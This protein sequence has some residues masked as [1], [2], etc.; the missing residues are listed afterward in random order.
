MIDPRGNYGGYIGTYGDNL[1]D[2]AKLAHDLY[3]GYS[4]MVANTK[5]NEIVRKVF[6]E[7][8]KE[9]NLPTDLVLKGGLVL[10]ATCIPLHSDDPDRQDRF[11]SYVETEINSF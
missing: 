6:L 10:L 4:A 5:P 1:Y 11:R 3:H 7:K 2:W 8:L 9:T